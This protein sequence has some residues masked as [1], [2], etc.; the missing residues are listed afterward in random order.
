MELIRVIHAERHKDNYGSPRV[1]LDLKARGVACCEN[2]VAKVMKA[3]GIRAVSGRVWRPATTDSN[4]DLPV[5]ANVLNREFHA[6]RP[7]QAWVSDITYLATGSGWLYL[8]LVVDLFS[9]RIVGWSMD[10]R[11]TSRLVVDALLMGLGRRDVESGLIVHSDRGSQYCSR[12]YRDILREQDLVASMSR[13]AN[14]WD[15]AV[16]ESTFARIKSELVHRESYADAEEARA[17]VFEYVEVFWN[18]ERRHSTLGGV[19][20]QEYEQSHNPDTP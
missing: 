8:A 17:S 18:R 14:C 2:T 11:M 7:N 5:S 20:P 16:A 12:H 3:A 19:C 10:V 9:R 13:R 15:N 1:T 4:H 6:T